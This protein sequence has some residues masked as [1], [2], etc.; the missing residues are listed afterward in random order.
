MCKYTCYEYQSDVSLS[1]KETTSGTTNSS[2]ALVAEYETEEIQNLRNAFLALTILSLSKFPGKFRITEIAQNL[3]TAQDVTSLANPLDGN[4]ISFTYKHC[5][6]NSSN[7]SSI[8]LTLMGNQQGYHEI[9]FKSDAS[10][11]FISSPVFVKR[12][13]SEMTNFTRLKYDDIDINNCKRNRSFM[14]AWSEDGTVGVHEGWSRKAHLV[15]SKN[16]SASGA[17]LPFQNWTLWTDDEHL[18]RFRILN[19]TAARECPEPTSP[20]DEAWKSVNGICY[21]V[22]TE[23]R[24][25][26]D[27]AEQCMLEGG[28]LLEF[29]SREGFTHAK[30][31]M[32]GYG[33][34][35]KVW[36]GGMHWEWVTQEEKFI[37]AQNYT[38]FTLRPFQCL[39]VQ[40][41]MIIS[42]NCD[43]TFTEFICEYNPNSKTSV[44]KDGWILEENT[45]YKVMES[46]EKL[47]HDQAA[48]AC[49]ALDATLASSFLSLHVDIKI[50][51]SNLLLN[52]TAWIGVKWRTTCIMRHSASVPCD[53]SVSEGRNLSMDFEMESFFLV[54]Q[55][56][57]SVYLP[58]ACQKNA[59]PVEYHCETDRNYD[60][61]CSC[62]WRNTISENWTRNSIECQ[63][64][65]GSLPILKTKQQVDFLVG[66][67]ANDTEYWIGLCDGAVNGVYRWLDTQ[68]VTWANWT[69]GGPTEFIDQCATIDGSGQFTNRDQSQTFELLCQSNPASFCAL[70]NI[71]MTRSFREA[72]EM[73][74]GKNMILMDDP[75]LAETNVLTWLNMK[76]SLPGRV[77]NET[78]NKYPPYSWP[79]YNNCTTQPCCVVAERSETHLQSWLLVNCESGTQ[80][81]SVTC[82]HLEY[83]YCM[84]SQAS[85][86]HTNKT[87]NSTTNTVSFGCQSGFAFVDGYDE[88]T[89][90][91]SCNSTFTE[92]INCE[93]HKYDCEKL[94]L[95]GNCAEE[96]FRKEC[97]TFCLVACASNC[98][99]LSTQC[100]VFIEKGLCNTSFTAVCQLSCGLC[101]ISTE[102]ITAS[103]QTSET[104]E[105]TGLFEASPTPKTAASTLQDHFIESTITDAPH[106]SPETTDRVEVTNA[107]GLTTQITEEINMGQTSTD[108]DANSPVNEGPTPKSLVYEWI[109]PPGGK[110]KFCPNPPD[111][112][113]AF[114][115][116]DALYPGS[117]VTYTCHVGFEFRAGGTSRTIICTRDYNWTVSE[118]EDCQA[119]TC[120][121][122]PKSPKMTTKVEDTSVVGSEAKF[123][124]EESEEQ[125]E[126]GVALMSAECSA[127]GQWSMEPT[128]CIE[129]C[130]APPF[131]E[132]AILKE[133]NTSHGQ[134]AEY[135]CQRGFLF[136]SGL[137]RLRIT[138]WSGGAWDPHTPGN[139]LDTYCEKI[140]HVDQ[141]ELNTTDSVYGSAVEISCNPGY[142]LADG[143]SSV[144]MVCQD[145]LQWSKNISQCT[146]TLF[147]N[148]T[149]ECDG[150]Y[151]HEDGYTS[152]TITCQT[153]GEWSQVNMSCGHSRCPPVPEI[154]NANPNTRLSLLQTRVNYTCKD[155]F[156][157]ADGSQQTTARCNG[158][159]W[160]VAFD[161]DGCNAVNCGPPPQLNYDQPL[162]S[163]PS[164]MNTTLGSNVSYQCYPGY[165]FGRGTEVE[166]TSCL[167]DGN[168]GSTNFNCEAVVC[169]DIIQVDGKLVD[170]LNVH[171]GAEVNVSCPES[172]ILSTKRSHMI[173]RCLENGSWDKRIP[174]CIEK[175][176]P[177]PEV[178]PVEAK[179]S[180]LIGVVA[181]LF[182]GFFCLLVVAVDA[183]SISRECKRLLGNIHT[184]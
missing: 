41:H 4:S 153:N 40:P 23:K 157:F 106:S 58:Y 101:G 56:D 9:L 169:P 151:R 183:P 84:L 92:C 21:K 19:N 172:A 133:V 3:P 126:I 175:S 24:T 85:A 57:S 82:R 34:T 154:S 18:I 78:S 148:V 13:A 51:L 144:V 28:Y 150:D 149:Y 62:Y 15:A 72:Y 69:D 163:R 173:I 171:P 96:T 50:L 90:E 93:P 165:W 55:T 139:C 80:K 88:Q 44:C 98:Q 100:D 105:T 104:S 118:M 123:E 121:N 83:E 160:N 33:L 2:I 180:D 142:Y 184:K 108:P 135:E 120:T 125:F 54:D 7:V 20:C 97:P 159:V 161:G 167:E 168:W 91:C 131:V 145:D 39:A 68:V 27:A 59:N 130:G 141:A 60:A 26:Q 76:Y 70:Y 134:I 178:E 75:N 30:R 166:T 114:K 65:G 46:T 115:K 137:R 38:S 89:V 71:G 37:D 158:H 48:Q 176:R 17:L 22:Y 174:D 74:Q 45:C 109:M 155:G 25:R 147:S 86:H 94:A 10:S 81:F 12:A 47:V 42:R 95:N 143:S 61:N 99:D 117:V 49:R 66:H 103:K 79:L 156:V 67:L 146:V 35:S 152:K 63:S 53:D 73:C 132:N 182:I 29:S 107:P 31:H 6:S 181:G 138:C 16:L 177:K 140:P 128:Q 14:I 124:C 162:I 129:G 43:S 5:P 52:S 77:I 111:V 110:A 11:N 113:N 1:V 136:S 102:E 164:F 32:V 36:V 116:I 119:K 179:G 170:S 112:R 127:N 122:P 87:Y 64:K 8:H